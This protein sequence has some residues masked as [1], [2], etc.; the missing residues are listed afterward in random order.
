MMAQDGKERETAIS[1]GL[2]HA[3]LACMFTLGWGNLQYYVAATL[4]NSNDATVKE[5]PATI[6]NVLKG[7]TSA[8]CILNGLIAVA[9]SYRSSYCLLFL[10]SDLFIVLIKK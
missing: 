10:L 8:D 4:I 1:Y 6:L 5:L 9:S 3:G 7:M 2:G